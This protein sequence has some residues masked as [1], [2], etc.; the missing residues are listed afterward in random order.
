M[1]NDKFDA[2]TGGRLV[3]CYVAVIAVNGFRAQ[4]LLRSFIAQLHL[5][6]VLNVQISWNRE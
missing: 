4:R 1:N 2:I 3:C 5:C 6:F